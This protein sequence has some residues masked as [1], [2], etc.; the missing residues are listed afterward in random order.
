MTPR[1]KAMR[2]VPLDEAEH[3][4]LLDFAR[5]GLG[6]ADVAPNASREVIIARLRGLGHEVVWL[7]DIEQAETPT[8]IA[9]RAGADGEDRTD[10]ATERWVQLSIAPQKDIAT[11]QRIDDT[12]YISIND[13]SAALPRGVPFWCAEI[14]F[15]HLKKYCVVH[16]LTQAPRNADGTAGKIHRYTEDRYHVDFHK[17]GGVL[18]DNPTPEGWIE[19]ERVVGPDGHVPPEV[20]LSHRRRSGLGAHPGMM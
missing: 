15:V 3:R 14:F 17:Y 16:R 1:L 13:R 19:G 4:H 2:Q 20:L 6:L 9:A 18:R 5:M 10:P 7:A 11:G 12:V 8:A